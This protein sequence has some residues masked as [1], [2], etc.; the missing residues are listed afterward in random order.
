MND[1]DF[2]YPEPY[3]YSVDNRR[4]IQALNIAH[5]ADLL[6]DLYLRVCADL[7]FREIL[8]QPPAAVELHAIGH[9]L[10]Y[11]TDD[12]GLVP[13]PILNNLEILE[14]LGEALGF[15]QSDNRPH[16][17]QHIGQSHVTTNPT[18]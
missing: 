5:R 1:Q 8:L 7:H 2:E 9:T 12:R 10:L 18:R 14:H 16:E 13:N 4:N 3:P 17:E 6:Y 11:L 15:P